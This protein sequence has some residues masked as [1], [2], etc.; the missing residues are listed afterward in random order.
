MI[1][2]RRQMPRTYEPIITP[3][4][5]RSASLS[6][7]T[8]NWQSVLAAQNSSVQALD[9]ASLISISGNVSNLASPVST[10]IYLPCKPGCWHF[11]EVVEFE[12]VSTK[13]VAMVAKQFKQLQQ[14]PHVK[15]PDS[16]TST[17]QPAKAPQTVCKTDRLRLCG[18][19][20]NRIARCSCALLLSAEEE[21]HGMHAAELETRLSDCHTKYV[22]LLNVRDWVCCAVQAR[23]S[24]ARCCSTCG[25]QLMCLKGWV[26]WVWK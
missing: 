16:K 4:C 5:W 3:S 18:A 23:L 13:F 11:F 9:S 24:L 14:R 26:T 8:Y 6:D 1:C 21:C 7:H 2:W 20:H 22:H 15:K 25:E 10:L 19:C 17:R 12:F